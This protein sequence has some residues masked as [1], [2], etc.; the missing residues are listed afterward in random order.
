[1]K[2]LAF[3]NFKGS[4][5]REFLNKTLEFNNT[6]FFYETFINAGDCPVASICDIKKMYHWLQ[7]GVSWT[8]EHIVCFLETVE[9]LPWLHK[10]DLKRFENMMRC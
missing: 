3:F 6:L 8:L 9:V 10:I 5:V 1:M 2:T 4:T 7:L